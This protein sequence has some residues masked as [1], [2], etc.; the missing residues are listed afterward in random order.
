[1][2]AL[3]SSIGQTLLKEPQDTLSDTTVYMPSPDFSGIRSNT[4]L[5]TKLH[6]QIETCIKS[7]FYMYV[8]LTHTG[9]FWFW[10]GFYTSY[11]KVLGSSI[12]SQLFFLNQQGLLHM[13]GWPSY[14]TDVNIDLGFFIFFFDKFCNLQPVKFN[15]A[16]NA[17]AQHI[18]ILNSML[19][20]ECMYTCKCVHTF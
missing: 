1:M 17:H 5:G 12:A 11:R 14:Y 18:I 20:C 16:Y 2:N 13:A 19:Y 6:L 9:Y 10:T 4:G 8:H 15:T 7:P 3:T